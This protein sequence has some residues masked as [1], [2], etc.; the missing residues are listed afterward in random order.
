MKTEAA[1]EWILKAD[2]DKVKE[3]C[4]KNLKK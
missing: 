4:E 2:D 3:Y 1:V